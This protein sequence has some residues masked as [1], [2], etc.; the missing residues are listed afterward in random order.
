MRYIVYVDEDS[1]NKDDI[2]KML[3]NISFVP[4]VAFAISLKLVSL[5]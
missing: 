5:P 3:E 1:V 2:V 4:K